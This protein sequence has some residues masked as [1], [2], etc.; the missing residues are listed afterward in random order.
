MAK[1]INVDRG[2]FLGKKDFTLE[3]YVSEWVAW[4]LQITS[5]IS[6]SDDALKFYDLKYWVKE[7]AEKSFEKIYQEQQTVNK[8][9]NNK[10]YRLIGK[11]GEKSIAK[12][13][14]WAESEVK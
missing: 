7:L 2:S 14:T 5:I 11:A 8:P 3:E 4:S 9:E 6:D 13:N 1:T 10:Q 12:G